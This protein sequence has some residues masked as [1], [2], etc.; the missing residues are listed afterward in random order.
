MNQKYCLIGLLI[1][2]SAF[3]SF[4]YY[5]AKPWTVPAKDAQVRNPVKRSDPEALKL[6]RELWIRN[7]SSCHGAFGRG[8][9]P[10]NGQLKTEM[11]D[12][13]SAFVLGQTDGE[14]FY[15][16]SEGRD[17]MPA[18]K[19]TIPDAKGRWSIIHYIRSFRK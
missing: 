13:S 7:C 8:D 10:K 11:K 12:L 3:Y 15:K 1:I 5:Q 16:I 6:G 4:T 17:E 2:S 18:F 9:G 14:L 19:T